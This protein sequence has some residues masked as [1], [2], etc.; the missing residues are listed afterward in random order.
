LDLLQHRGVIVSQTDGQLRSGAGAMVD[1]EA[2]LPVD[3]TG[4]PMAER[5]I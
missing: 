1:F 5:G 2:P 3:Q 4:K